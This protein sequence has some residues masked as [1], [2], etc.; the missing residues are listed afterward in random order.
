MSCTVPHDV[1]MIR[2]GASASAQLR[3]ALIGLR[4][5][6]GDREAVRYS[7]KVF[8]I[9]GNMLGLLRRV[10]VVGQVPITLPVRRN[11]W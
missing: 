5:R 1:A 8:A 3:R 7:L 9:A 11:A 4:G 10:R 6:F 2:P